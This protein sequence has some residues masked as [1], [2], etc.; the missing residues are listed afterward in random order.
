MCNPQPDK[1]QVEDQANSNENLPSVGPIRALALSRKENPVWS[2][3]NY[4]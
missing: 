2:I 3:L 1:K 4:H